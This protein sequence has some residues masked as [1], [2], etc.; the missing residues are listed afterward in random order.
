L[1]GAARNGIIELVHVVSELGATLE[2]DGDVVAATRT[3]IEDIRLYDDLRDAAGS[4]AAAQRRIDNVEGLLGSLGRFAQKGKGRAALA[5]YLR[6]LSLETSDERED[7]GD[8]VVLTTLHGAKGLEFPIC[9]MIGLEEELLPH[10]RTLQPQV[11]DVLDADH[12]TDISEERRLCYVGIT[13]A[14]RKLYLTRACTRVQRGRSMQRTPSR[15]LLEV[16]DE[17]LEVRDIA[18]EARQKV[19]TDE[20]RSFFASLAIDE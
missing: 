20:V 18:E 7:S 4:L 9:F 10:I 14:Q 5:E 1:R 17:L 8:R 2:A 12:A 3:L 13:R 19:P 16:P 15:F 11:T 6:M